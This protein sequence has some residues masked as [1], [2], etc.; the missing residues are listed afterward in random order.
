LPPTDSFRAFL[1]Y[2]LEA[3][4]VSPAER[5]VKGWFMWIDAAL[6]PIAARLS[7]ERLA[8]LRIQLAALLGIEPFIVYRDICGLSNDAAAS[9]ATETAVSLL[10]CTLT[11]ESNSA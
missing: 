3:S 11:S 8:K 5:R 2:S 6:E 4:D 10:R 1:R 9:T 7:P